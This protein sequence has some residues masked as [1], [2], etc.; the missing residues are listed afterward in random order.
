M[1]KI[2]DFIKGFL[3][4][5]NVISEDFN[6]EEYKIFLMKKYII[7][8]KETHYT[9][10]YYPKIYSL[11]RKNKNKI[12]LDSKNGQ[13]ELFFIGRM[14]KNLQLI[15]GAIEL[16]PLVNN[17]RKIE[18]FSHPDFSKIKQEIELYKTSKKLEKF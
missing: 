17:V 14:S 6:D 3:P 8:K 18:V 9:L 13:M 15:W 12:E 10:G 4:I 5:N 11:I 2:L 7:F 1:S 16:T